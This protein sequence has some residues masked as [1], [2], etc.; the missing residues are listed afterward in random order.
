[1]GFPF[2]PGKAK[3][4][5]AVIVFMS[6]PAVA[7]QRLKAILVYQYAS[8]AGVKGISQKQARAQIRRRLVLEGNAI[9]SWGDD[10]QPSSR[11]SV[12]AC[13]R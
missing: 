6:T 8:A 5:S 2:S 11:A 4:D 9:V 7:S 13:L 1:V 10:P 12:A 3:V